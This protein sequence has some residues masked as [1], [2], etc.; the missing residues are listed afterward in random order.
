M[1]CLR[2]VDS[3]GHE[4]G[5]A[6]A[7]GASGWQAIRC[8]RPSSRDNARR[9][10][11]AAGWGALGLALL[12]VFASA[13]GAA[14]NNP[15]AY[16]EDV[17][18]YQKH[19][20]TFRN[21][22]AAGLFDAVSMFANST[23]A[24]FGMP[25][26]AVTNLF[27]C[28][29]RA[30]PQLAPF[31]DW[32]L[33]A[34]Q[35][36]DADTAVAATVSQA[37]GQSNSVRTFFVHVKDFRTG[38]WASAVDFRQGFA[39]GLYDAVSQFAKVVQTTTIDAQKTAAALT[40][41]ESKEQTLGQLR[42]WVDGD[43]QGSPTTGQVGAIAMKACNASV[44]D[45]SGPTATVPIQPN[46]FS[47]ASPA[48]PSTPSPLFAPPTIARP[49]TPAPWK[50][51]WVLIA[52]GVGAAGLYVSRTITAGKPRRAVAPPPPPDA[53]VAPPAPAPQGASPD[54]IRQAAQTEL[55]GALDTPPQQPALEAA[56]ISTGLWLWVPSRAPLELGA[57]TRLS[58][59]DLGGRTNAV[60]ADDVAAIVEPEPDTPQRFRLRNRSDRTWWVRPPNADWSELAS[61][62][63]TP[64]LPGMTMMVGEVRV[65]VH[66]WNV[67]PVRPV[68]QPRLRIGERVV[69]VAGDL[70]FYEY[71]LTGL[72]AKAGDGVVARVT[73][74]SSDDPVLGLQNLSTVTWMATPPDSGPK[75][76][77]P[78]RTVRLRAGMRIACGAA[79]IDVE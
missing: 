16:F 9:A 61:G 53:P 29:D 35:T 79:T 73:L 69:T 26:S 59:R 48:F 28:L 47:P 33:Q 58:A 19:T 76:I 71:D 25:R 36:A 5:A 40:C 55:G 46:P 78:G 27:Q 32:M 10:R 51:Y 62:T 14:A 39:A 34:V 7:T 11:P 49:T 60:G 13:Q 4:S 31:S 74:R 23:S 50:R 20:A 6:G 24:F 15:G 72:D 56:P 52:I 43:L 41:L 1:F 68:W 66:P 37:C 22:Y 18:T 77:E 2:H 70:Q 65:N 3:G 21:G 45:L 75:P 42:S 38:G 63:A 8:V 30:S 44:A 64:L 17:N 54:P 12:I 67:P 57:G